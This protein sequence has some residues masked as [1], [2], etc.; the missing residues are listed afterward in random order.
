V[1]LHAKK[2]KKEQRKFGRLPATRYC[3]YGQPIFC[4]L[5]FYFFP[6]LLIRSCYNRASWYMFQIEKAAQH[7]GCAAFLRTCY[8]EVSR[9]ELTITA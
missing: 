6:E 9:H 1:E 4:Y 3:G 2:T 5:R 8:R 7:I